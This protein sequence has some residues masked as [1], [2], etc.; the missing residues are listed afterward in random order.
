MIGI[1]KCA[2][3]IRGIRP[4]DENECII[5]KQLVDSFL[6]V[7]VLGAHCKQTC[8]LHR[9][10]SSVLEIFQQHSTTCLLKS[11]IKLMKNTTNNTFYFLLPQLLL[12][13][14]LLLQLRLLLL[15]LP[16]IIIIIMLILQPRLLLLLLRLLLLLLWLSF[17]PG[18]H[19]R[20]FNTLL[21]V[22]TL[23]TPTSHHS[24]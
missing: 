18:L 6:R 21:P 7:F 22:T 20:T 23:T 1:E 5:F 3:V 13:P 14:L 12:L 10:M 15:L 17:K 8:E 9:H 2:K 19:E 11:D 16:I 24:H 4:Q